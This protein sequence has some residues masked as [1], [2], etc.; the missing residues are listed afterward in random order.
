[1]HVILTG[2][3]GLANG[4]DAEVKFHDTHRPDGKDD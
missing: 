1:M 4:D 3:Q 2:A